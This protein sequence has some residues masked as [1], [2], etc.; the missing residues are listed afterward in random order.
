MENPRGRGSVFD[1]RSILSRGRF[2]P[3]DIMQVTIN[4]RIGSY[5]EYRGLNSMIK[6]VGSLKVYRI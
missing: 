3:V 5:L 6:I 1:P 2:N 4:R